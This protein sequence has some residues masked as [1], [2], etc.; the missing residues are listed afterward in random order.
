MK[1]KL[2][3]V[4]GVLFLCFLSGC[5]TE[6]E[7][8]LPDYQTKLVVEGYIE[9]GEVP[10]VMISKSIPYFSSIDINYLLKNVLITDA[11]VTVT[12][13]DGESEQLTLQYNDKSP[14]Y[15]AYVGK[16]LKGQLNTDYTLN[17]KWKDREYSAKT[18]ILH[19]FDLDSIG[20]SSS[21]ELYS[22]TMKSVRALF[23]DNSAEI[24][25]YQF[26]IKIH[27]KDLHDRL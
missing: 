17:I 16:N 18:S 26:M 10:I 6:I 14:Y 25:Y 19:T 23:T 7:V 4:L 24:N 15:I 20:F 1:K 21:N 12:A 9:N 22:D 2:I 13:S 5:Q 3:F 8:D 27:G 11:V